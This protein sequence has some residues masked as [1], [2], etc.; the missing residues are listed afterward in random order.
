VC[1]DRERE[2]EKTGDRRLGSHAPLANNK[3]RKKN[4]RGQTLIRLIGVASRPQLRGIRYYSPDLRFPRCSFLFLPLLL[5]SGLYILLPR[6]SRALLIICTSAP[7]HHTP[8][9]RC[10]LRI[11]ASIRAP[12]P[13]PNPIPS[14]APTP[15]CF[16]L[17]R[18]PKDAFNCFNINSM[19]I[20]RLSA[21]FLASHAPC[22]SNTQPDSAAFRSSFLFFFLNFLSLR[23]F[24]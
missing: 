2:R 14:P 23:L 6:C 19:F 1:V 11:Y 21:S 22:L 8:P 4:N 24:I 18:S 15:E 12:N 5:F 16:T 13:P 17:H 3:T 20:K 9:D 10:I 7:P